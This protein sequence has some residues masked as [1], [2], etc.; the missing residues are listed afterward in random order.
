MSLAQFRV[1]LDS[2]RVQVIDGSHGRLIVVLQVNGAKNVGLVRRAPPAVHRTAEEI[3]HVGVSG[4]IVLHRHWVKSVERSQQR[5]GVFFGAIVYEGPA[6][7]GLAS[8]D[9]S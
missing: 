9:T 4:G 1:L 3:D 2:L 7:N 5:Y 6:D 8:M